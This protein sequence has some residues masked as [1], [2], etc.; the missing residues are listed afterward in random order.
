MKNNKIILL[1]IA[2]IY[3]ITFVPAVHAGDVL[4]ITSPEN[5]SVISYKTNVFEVESPDS[6]IIAKTIF[7]LDG[8]F[9]GNGDESGMLTYDSSLT[10]G[11]HTLE[12]I[13]LY[14][15]GT[16]EKAVSAFTAA[17]FPEANL[18]TFDELEEKT[19]STVA[20][21]TAADAVSYLSLASLAPECVRPTGD[22]GASLSIAADE[23]NPSDKYIKFNF[24]NVAKRLLVG[25]KIGFWLN[26]D[27][28]TVTGGKVFFECDI[29]LSTHSD[30]RLRIVPRNASHSEWS[31]LQ[32]IEQKVINKGKGDMEE[33]FAHSAEW[34][35]L[36]LVYDIDN[37]TVSGS[38]GTHTIQ[39]TEVTHNKAGDGKLAYFALSCQTIYNGT[40]IYCIDN[41]RTGCLGEYTGIE[42]MWFKD[43]T[44]AD[45]DEN[46]Y[47]DAESN[48]VNRNVTELKLKLSSKLDADTVTK[49]NVKVVAG[50]KEIAVSE[51]VY[52]ESE[53]TV[54]IILDNDE[55]LTNG[56]SWVELS[57]KI[58]LSGE[59]L[60]IGVATVK[61]FKLM[62]SGVGISD[63]AF[64]N[65][66]T[67]VYSVEQLSAGDTL[68][69]NITIQNA[70]GSGQV[71]TAVLVVKDG[72]R[73]LSVNPV[74][75]EVPEGEESFP[76][77]VTSKEITSAENL[78]ASVIFVSSL[79]EAF[80]IDSADLN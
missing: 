22:P 31:S 55:I 6:K 80:Y 3:L 71:L 76:A 50:G 66:E 49:E 12:V 33:T 45:A 37:M 32:I 20:G 16:A 56:N 40:G 62:P 11:S 34:V 8:N 10:I 46:G 2:V 70:S 23:T 9:V 54:I 43:E 67:N 42:K 28:S 36:Y 29:K 79:S 64:C 27:H 78:S 1:L 58:K 57:E 65:E 35:R 38:L 18:M 41:V 21:D 5:G 68:T 61:S 51:V 77:S 13:A 48:E 53:G 17:V 69:A 14:D 15:D 59:A 24:D 7:K 25:Q 60:P 63:V 4:T 30:L 74:L 19:F 72:K 73:F 44:N 75:I 47:V 26:S 52:S 39:E